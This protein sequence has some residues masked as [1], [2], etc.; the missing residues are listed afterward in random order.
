MNE[1][2]FRNAK[3]ALAGSAGHQPA[4]LAA[5]ELMERAA[6]LVRDDALILENAAF[7]KIARTQAAASLVQLFINEQ[8]IRK[9]G[10]AYAQIARTVQRAGVVGA[11]IMGG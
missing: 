9:R 3:E 4:A 10:K 6:G 2:A 5:V 1:P 8:T 7:A 11:G